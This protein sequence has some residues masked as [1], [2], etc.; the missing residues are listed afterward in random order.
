MP[1]EGSNGRHAAQVIEQVQ[2]ELQS[3]LQQRA[4]IVKRI[5]LIK[6]TIVGIA[7]VFG[8]DALSGALLEIVERKPHGR[9]PGFTGT[10]RVVLMESSAPLSTHEV[11]QEIVRRAP[12]LIARHKDP[13]ASVNTVLSRLVS[14][15]EASVVRDKAGR[16]AWQW[17]AA[18]ART[19]Q[20]NGFRSMS[21]DFSDAFPTNEAE[22]ARRPCRD[23]AS[24]G[25]S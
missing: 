9:N 20:E 7:K 6:Q 2:K 10:C 8:N 22:V 11:C 5:G 3:L 12:D 1:N 18:A 13:L 14:Y 15:G 16:R 23:T 17:S 24:M 4:E 21:A 19:P 25:R